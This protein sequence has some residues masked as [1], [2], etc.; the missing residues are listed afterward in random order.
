LTEA[1]ALGGLTVVARAW[2]VLVAVV[3]TEAPVVILV[4][5]PHILLALAVAAALSAQM[6]FPTVPRAITITDK[7]G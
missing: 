7:A 5:V 3:A 1:K 6:A 2:E 4:E